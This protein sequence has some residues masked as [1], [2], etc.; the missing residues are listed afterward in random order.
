VTPDKDAG[1][2]LIELAKQVFAADSASEAGFELAEPKKDQ[3]IALTRPTEEVPTVERQQP[4]QIKGL[5]ESLATLGPEPTLATEQPKDAPT[6]SEVEES[7]RNQERQWRTATE[8]AAIILQALRKIADAPE[9]GFVVTVYG[10]NPWNAM[11]T[12]TPEAGRVKDAELWRTR[13]Q[14]IGVRLRQDFDVL[15]DNLG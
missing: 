14:D 10:S 9:R 15:E 1:W 5:V 7:K 11:L 13:V 8:L 3:E 2:T 6:A 4:A 12:I